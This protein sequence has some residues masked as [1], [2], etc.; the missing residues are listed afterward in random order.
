VY[1]TGSLTLTSEGKRTFFLSLGLRNSTFQADQG[2][3][4]GIIRLKNLRTTGNL[5]NKTFTISL[6]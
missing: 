3:I 2:I 5:K 4:G 6:K 1:S